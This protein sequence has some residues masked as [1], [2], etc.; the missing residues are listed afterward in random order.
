ML[1]ARDMS[2]FCKPI[3]HYK[4]CV[5]P[6]GFWEALHKIHGDVFSNQIRDV[7]TFCCVTRSHIFSHIFFLVRGQNH[8]LAIGL[9]FR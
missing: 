4:N 9:K 7:Q 6:Y 8:S 3:H 5:K 2:M 1:K